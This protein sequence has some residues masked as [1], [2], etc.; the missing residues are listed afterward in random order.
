RL[1]PGS[2]SVVSSPC[3]MVIPMHESLSSPRPATLS[4]R[5]PPAKVQ[6]S[7][8]SIGNETLPR[9]AAFRPQR[10]RSLS[11]E[12][13]GLQPNRPSKPSPEHRTSITD[14]EKTGRDP[15][16]KATP[17]TEHARGRARGRPLLFCV[18]WHT[19]EV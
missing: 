12:G 6:G 17:A 8:R 1:Q 7:N 14:E 19:E 3:G 4:C 16:V 10:E 5:T 18:V 2:C 9:L 15:F 11:P 13:A